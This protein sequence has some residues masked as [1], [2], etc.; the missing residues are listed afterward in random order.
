MFQIAL[1]SDSSQCYSIWS[2]VTFFKVVI[3][4]IVIELK[5]VIEVLIELL[6]RELNSLLEK[7]IKYYEFEFDAEK[8]ES[9]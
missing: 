2:R 5:I 7:A 3:E 8:I 9:K 1:K 6:L 4:L